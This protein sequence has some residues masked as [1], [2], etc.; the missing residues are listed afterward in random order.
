MLEFSLSVLPAPSTC[1]QIYTQSKH[2][3]VLKMFYQ[4]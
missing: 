4:T 2:K 3:L 1:H